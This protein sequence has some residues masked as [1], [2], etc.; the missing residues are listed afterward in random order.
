[1]KVVPTYKMWIN[2][3]KCIL[4]NV[5]PTLKISQYSQENTCVGISFNK[6]FSCNMKCSCK[7][8]SLG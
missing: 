4:H 2:V 8:E 7:N 5:A 3:D 6:T 1:M